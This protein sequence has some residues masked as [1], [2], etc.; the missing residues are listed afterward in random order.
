MSL[1]LLLNNSLINTTHWKIKTIQWKGR[2]IYRNYPNG[3]VKATTNS[4]AKISNMTC[5]ILRR[6]HL[7]NLPCRCRERGY[8]N[9]KTKESRGKRL[10]DLTALSW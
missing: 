1:D 10:F 7:E 6:A 2:G 3:L 9:G 4:G 5:V 8:P